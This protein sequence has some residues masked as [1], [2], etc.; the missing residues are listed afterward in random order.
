MSKKNK[1]NSHQSGI[2]SGVLIAIIGLISAIVLALINY[3]PFQKW[4]DTKLNPTATSI[5]PATEIIIIEISE[6]PTLMAGFTSTPAIIETPTVNLINTVTL[7]PITQQVMHAKL[8][9]N[10]YDGKAPL[11]ATFNA[12]DSFVEIVGGEDLYCTNHNACQ[13]TWDVRL[14]G[15]TIFGPTSGEG[16]F[17]YRFENRGEYTVVVNVCRG[18]GSGQ[19]CGYSAVVIKLR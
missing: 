18:K 12:Y 17:T 16:T 3:P 8:S 6:T 1:K 13:Y 5:P 15:K 19:I 14:N 10:A 4:W 9:T 7:T 11:V 2:D